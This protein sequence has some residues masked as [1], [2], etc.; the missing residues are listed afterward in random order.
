VGI[1]GK[2]RAFKQGQFWKMVGIILEVQ[3]GSTGKLVLPP[4]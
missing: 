2:T 1:K 4:I 3:S